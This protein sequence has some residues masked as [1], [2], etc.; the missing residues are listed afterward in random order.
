MGV[1]VP[2]LAL[3]CAHHRSLL[4]NGMVRKND[5][6]TCAWATTD[7]ARDTQTGTKMSLIEAGVCKDIGDF[8]IGAGVGHNQADQSWTKGGS[9]KFNGEHLVLEAAQQ[10][11]NGIEGSVLGYYGNFNTELNRHYLNSINVDSST[12]K[13]TATSIALRARARAEWKDAVKQ[14]NVSLSPYA[15]YTYTQTKLDGYTETGGGFP[16][17]FDAATF[18]SN[19][20]RLGANLKTSI[21]PATDVKVGVELAHRFEKNTTGVNGKVIGLYDFSLAGEKVK[22]DWARL[23]VDVDYRITDDAVLTAGAN[24][25]TK[26]GDASWGVTAGL[27]IRF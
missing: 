22:Q 21:N 23:L 13:P 25:A 20:L 11:A 26:G 2:S 1:I 6:G 5:N 3:F 16:A 24:V 18:K 10:F 4:D 7:A 9:A 27:R 15:A 14:S 19:D 8:R 17:Q 12:A